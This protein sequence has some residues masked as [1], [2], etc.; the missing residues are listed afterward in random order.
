MDF[1]LETMFKALV[2]LAGGAVVTA[3]VVGFVVGR[4]TA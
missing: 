2:V 3:F 4:V 1:G